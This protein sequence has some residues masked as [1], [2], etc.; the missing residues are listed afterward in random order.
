MPT[1]SALLLPS[2][3]AWTTYWLQDFLLPSLLLAFREVLGL[4]ECLQ[5]QMWLAHPRDPPQVSSSATCKTSSLFYSIFHF[6]L[7]VHATLPSAASP[8]VPGPPTTPWGLKSPKPAGPADRTFS[9]H[10]GFWPPK[11]NRIGL[12]VS[13]ACLELV[14]PFSS[15]F[16]PFGI[17]MPVMCVSHCCILG[18]DNLLSRFHRSG[19]GEKFCSRMDCAQSLTHTWFKMV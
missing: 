3:R 13:Q 1:N 15:P 17:G 12:A 16:L 10:R 2:S 5:L 11:P 7:S 18:A 9:R 14:P 8:K 19:D 4:P 6:L